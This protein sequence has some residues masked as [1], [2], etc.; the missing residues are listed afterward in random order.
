[1]FLLDHFRGRHFQRLLLPNSMESLIITPTAPFEHLMCAR[2][3]AKNFA[4]NLLNGYYHLLCTNE[5]D[6]VTNPSSP[7]AIGGTGIQP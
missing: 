6:Q 4:F 3:R 7:E 2:L 1:M 5:E